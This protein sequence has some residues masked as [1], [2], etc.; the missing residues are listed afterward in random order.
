[1]DNIKVGSKVKW[2][3]KGG[4]WCEG[5]VCE[6]GDIECLVHPTGLPY[7]STVPTSDL[8]LIFIPN[9]EDIEWKVEYNAKIPPTQHNCSHPNVVKSH[10]LGKSFL[11]CRTCKKEV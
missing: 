8:E 9:T 4:L 10:A 6:Y 2:K 11:Y 5:E 3:N 1:M 7:F